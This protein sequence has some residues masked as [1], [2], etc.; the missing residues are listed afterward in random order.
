MSQS[1]PATMSRVRGRGFR[2]QPLELGEF[3]K[4]EGALTCLSILFVSAGEA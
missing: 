3:H 4:A 1:Y 2:P